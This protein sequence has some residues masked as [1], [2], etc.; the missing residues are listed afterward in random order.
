MDNQPVGKNQLSHLEDT[1]AYRVLLSANLLTTKYRKK[2]F[3]DIFTGVDYTANSTK[4]NDMCERCKWGYYWCPILGCI[5]YKCTHTE[6]FVPAGH[7]GL[8]MDGEQRYLFAQPGMHNISS[9]WIKH[10]GTKMLPA[11][12]QLQHG[13]RVI[14]VVEQGYL[15][16]ASDNGQPVLLP[17]GIHVWTSETLHYYLA[18]PLDQHLLNLGPYT[19]ITVDEG[20][21][22]VTQ[23]NGK[24]QILPGGHTHLLTHKNW[25][26]EKLLTL[27]IQTDDLEKIN[28]TS[29]DNITMLITSTVTWKIV[30][31]RRAATM[32]AETM[33]VSGRGD[34]PAEMNKLRQDVLK[35]AIASLASFV[36][37]VNYSDSFHMAAKAQH[38][39]HEAPRREVAV[40]AEPEEEGKCVDNPLYDTTRMTDCVKH[41]NQTTNAYGV[42]I[43]SINIVSAVPVD[44]ELTKALA[45]GAVA[46]A[47]ALQAETAA[48]GQAKAT[49]ID[50]EAV[51]VKTRIAAEGAAQATLTKAKSSA[52]A[53]KLVADGQKKAAELLATS[54]VAVDLAR[55]DKSAALMGANEK[56]FFGQE[57]GYLSN[58][59][60]KGSAAKGPKANLF[61]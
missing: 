49:R 8:F 19:L 12:D 4:A 27:K 18:V 9:V 20:Y 40:R 60:L 48:R 39:S 16:L 33:S 21:C 53:A 10:V 43:L 7:V 38:L 17:P 29:A 32:A 56:Y 45:C 34:V 1:P 15:G 54:Q 36:G 6:V 14:L 50:A 3:E 46:S 35:Q 55:I 28:A 58:L 23:N 11:N 52:E 24:Q 42:E 5:L 61:G 30:D 57:P 26:F 59:V 13:N 41:A 47:Q 22:A 44:E 37:G 25:R 31:A 2:T 51:A